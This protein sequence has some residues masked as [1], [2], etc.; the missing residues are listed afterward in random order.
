M[1]QVLAGREVLGPEL[2]LRPHLPTMEP[3]D[4]ALTHPATEE[5][6]SVG[7]LGDDDTVDD[8]IAEWLAVL[9]RREVALLFHRYEHD[10]GIGER[11]L[12]ARFAQWWVSLKR[13]ASA[14][15]VSGIGAATTEEAA[16][17]LVGS[18]VEREYGALNAAEFRPLTLSADRL[19]EAVR[20]TGSSEDALSGLNLDCE[21]AA[22]LTLAADSSRS[23]QLSV[24]ALQSGAELAPQRSQIGPDG[25]TII[26]TPRGRVLSEHRSEDGT[27]WLVLCPGSHQSI[28]RAVVRMMRQL[29]ARE[30]WYSYRK[31]I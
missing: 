13:C 27:G 30:T 2:G 20:R 23:T 17:S 24:V 1:L 4:C 14:V 25:I 7:A 16:A 9:S 8:V 11:H 18:Y 12:L 22:I 15:H 5:L 21:Q 10:S 19:I 26:D 28:A 3:K 31:V 6:R 29:P